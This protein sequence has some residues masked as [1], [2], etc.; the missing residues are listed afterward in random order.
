VIASNVVSKTTLAGQV[1]LSAQDIDFTSPAAMEII[2]RDLA[3][4]YMLQSDAVACAAILAGD[5]ASGSTWTVTADDPTSLIS[6]LYDAATDILKA[7]NFL[8]DRLLL[9]IN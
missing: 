9:A 3:G 6:A 4:Q 7:T 5:T 8:P 2:L 1:T